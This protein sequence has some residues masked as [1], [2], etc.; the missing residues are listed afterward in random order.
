MVLGCSSFFYIKK[1]FLVRSP[2]GNPLHR[3]ASGKMHLLDPLY[4]LSEP[5]KMCLSPASEAK[6]NPVAEGGFSF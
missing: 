6:R 5:R 2:G 4:Q 1:F 3:V